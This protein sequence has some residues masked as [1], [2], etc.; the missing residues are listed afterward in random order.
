MSKAVSLGGMFREMNSWVPCQNHF[1]QADLSGI[2]TANNP[3]LKRAVNGW[4]NG[5]YDED[6][7]R[8]VDELIGILASQKS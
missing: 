6:P 4:S 8:L 1:E 2:T 5:E 7:H 3:R